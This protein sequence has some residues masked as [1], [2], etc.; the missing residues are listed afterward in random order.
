MLSFSI[1]IYIYMKPCNR[2]RVCYKYGSESHTTSKFFPISSFFKK[3]LQFCNYPWLNKFNATKTFESFVTL[4]T[5]PAFLKGG[6]GKWRGCW[7]KLPPSQT[8]LGEIK[9]VLRS[10]LLTQVL[11]DK[12][13]VKSWVFSWIVSGFCLQKRLYSSYMTHQIGH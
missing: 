8:L 1:Y 3:F 10:I 4:A 6:G 9:N 12:P 2:K 11:G 5:Q 7:I 13:W